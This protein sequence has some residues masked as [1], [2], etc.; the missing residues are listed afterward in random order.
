[1]GE[2]PFG[3]TY[4]LDADVQG[5][6]TGVVVVLET[7]GWYCPVANAA[8]GGDAEVEF[9][10]APTLPTGAGGGLGDTVM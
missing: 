6:A 4:T 3:L 5:E 1:M 2:G 10:K 8:T 7:Y 9:R